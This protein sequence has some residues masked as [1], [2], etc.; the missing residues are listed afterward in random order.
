[1][2]IQVIEQQIR[3]SIKVFPHMVTLAKAYLVNINTDN[4]NAFEALEEFIKLQGCSKPD[5]VVI[6]ESIDIDSQIKQVA[7]YFSFGIAFCE[8]IHILVNRSILIPR[9]SQTFSTPNNVGWTTV[10]PGSSGMSSG[11]NFENIN[12][13]TPLYLMKPF[14]RRNEQIKHTFFD[15]DIYTLELGI[16]NAHSEVIT[17]LSDGLKCFNND[18]FHPSII[19]LGKTVEGAWIEL[20]ISLALYIKAQKKD[21]ESFIDKLKGRDDFAW[22]VKE[23]IKLYERQDWFKPLKK[24]SGIDLNA[25]REVH[26]WTDIIRDSRNAIHFGA[27]PAT[28]NTYEKASIMYIGAVKHLRTLYKLKESAD[29]HL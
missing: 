5:T 14:S 18:L 29:K 26:N 17:A 9:G 8:A 25:L 19:M 24:E 10:I 1:M 23:V 20:G 4:I 27:E 2:N 28:P 12:I 22:K 21:F 13:P 3:D 6:H 7:E 16:Q 11:W 15:P